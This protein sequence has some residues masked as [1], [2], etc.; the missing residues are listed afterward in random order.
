MPIIVVIARKNDE[1][2]C[3]FLGDHHLLETF[4]TSNVGKLC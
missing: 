4:F 3:V 2:I 1:A